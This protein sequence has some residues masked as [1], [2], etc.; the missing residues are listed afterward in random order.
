MKRFLISA[1]ALIFLSS[2][3]AAVFGAADPPGYYRNGYMLQGRMAETDYDWWWHSLVA[4]NKDTG[5]LRPF[6]IEYYV[7]N[8]GLNTPEPVLGQLP[9][10][11]AGGKRPCYAMIKAGTW[12]ENSSAQ[13]HNFYPVSRFSAQT[14]TMDVVIGDNT[15]TDTAIVGSV[16]VTAEEA[17][18]HPEYMSDAGEMSWNLT[19]DKLLSYSLGYGTSEPFSRMNAF[20]MFWHIQGMLTEYSGTIIY[21]GQEYIVRPEISAGYQDKNW[22][23]DYTN[24]WIWF[25]C[26]N[27]KSADTG[28]KLRY[29]SLDVGGGLPMVFGLPLGEKVIIAFY[30]KGELYEFNFSKF[31]TRTRLELDCGVRADEVYW[32]VAAW[33]GEAAIEINF[34]CP[35]SHM[36]LF[37]Y[38][39]P[40][41]EK[42][43]TQLWN[44]GHGS[45]TVRLYKKRGAGYILIDTMQGTLGGCEY[46]R[47]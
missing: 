30:Y 13:L 46:G 7:V 10:N 47:Y 24:P 25:N 3:A 19:A 42:N 43:H 41:G 32:N 35:K 21:N 5:E 9:E 17:A 1:A 34:T 28:E 33:N 8:P 12:G 16:K 44:G 18:A 23:S 2:I 40:Q 36:Q 39:N 45:G 11:K 14:E 29:T 20:Q 27:F 6:F 31:W 15:A 37:N 4:E 26:N 22:G 38:E